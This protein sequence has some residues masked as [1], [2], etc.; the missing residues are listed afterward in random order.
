M[1]FFKIRTKKQPVKSVN[2]S[3]TAT[4]ED[5]LAELTTLEIV[6]MV[7]TIVAFVAQIVNL[8]VGLADHVTLKQVARKLQ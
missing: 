1:V 7:I 3:T 2:N 6:L 5:S 8:S 4:E